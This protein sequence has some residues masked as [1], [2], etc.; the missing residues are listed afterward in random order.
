MPALRRTL[1]LLAIFLVIAGT[2]GAAAA[3]RYYEA[4][5]RAHFRPDSGIV[6]MEIALSGIAVGCKA[7]L[8]CPA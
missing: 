1:P 5:Y 3:P 7:L 6:E 2:A 4:A 8:C